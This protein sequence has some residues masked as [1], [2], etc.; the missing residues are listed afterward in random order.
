MS[1][2]GN[3][4]PMGVTIKVCSYDKKQI[5]IPEH[6]KHRELHVCL[7]SVFHAVSYFCNCNLH[8]AKWTIME[9]LHHGL[10]IA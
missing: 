1:N 2:K 4:V 3:L 5:V 10:Y 6:N 7:M 8:N 9:N